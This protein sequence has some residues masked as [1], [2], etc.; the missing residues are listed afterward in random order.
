MS[1]KGPLERFIN[2][3]FQGKWWMAAN[4]MVVLFC[5]KYDIPGSAGYDFYTGVRKV[6]DE[7]LKAEK[8]RGKDEERLNKIWEEQERRRLDNG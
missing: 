8:E 4:E 7:E 1:L 6:W 2:R 5:E 3:K